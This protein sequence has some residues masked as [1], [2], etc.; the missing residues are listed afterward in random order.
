MPDVN[1]LKK[2]GM[3]GT[4]WNFLTTI[5]SQL[6]GLIVSM[7]LARLLDPTDFGV[8]AM[9]LVFNG[10]L[11][12]LIDFGFGNALVQKKEISEIEKS[13]TFYINIC[14]GF[15]FSFAIFL[16]SPL[17]ARYFEM[18]VLNNVVKVTSVSFLIG[19]FSVVQTALFQREMKF[20]PIFHARWISSIVSGLL[21]IIF[22]LLGFGVWSLV[23]SNLT[24]W[25]LNTMIIWFMSSW[26]PSFVFNLKAISNLWDY[27]WK[28]TLSTLINRVFVQIDTFVIGKVYNAVSLGLYN[29]AQSLNR[30]IV[31]YSFSSIR[32]TLLPSLSK[33]QSDKDQ[34]RECV[35]KLIQVICFLNFFFSGLMYVCGDN[36]I[37]I[38]YGHKWDDAIPIFKILAIFS[39]QFSLPVLYDTVMTSL[40]RMNMYF[41]INL[42]RKPLL[43]V[44]IPIGIYYGFYSYIWCLN[45]A[46][47]IGLI[48]YF[49]STYICCNLS[50]KSQ[51]LSICKYIVPFAINL[52]FFSIFTIPFNI[53]F[54][55][56]LLKSI[57][58][59]LIYI[60]Y[61]EIFKCQGY[62]I[63][64]RTLINLIIE[65]WKKKKA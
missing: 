24:S 26:R 45:I 3:A 55:N 43:I 38:I 58:F 56:L 37:K 13:T 47:L 48:P 52:I 59:C 21:G 31:D 62:M 11:E 5:I 32:P 36:I 19:S 39:I 10:V 30:L 28:L 15:L 64:K 17:M 23:I 6:R 63:C 16:C 51:I 61:C 53:E 29:R 8:I 12:T 60:G 57:L 44:A 41:W 4:I 2:A 42:I 9:A 18:P 34:Y 35:V 33:L 54:L 1:S 7:V 46:C 25:I 65:K 49:W 22:A 27:G 20:K 50:I 14:V 40:A